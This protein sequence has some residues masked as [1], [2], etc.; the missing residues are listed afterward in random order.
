[1]RCPLD[2]SAVQ[3]AAPL[4]QLIHAVRK[5]FV[6]DPGLTERASALLETTSL[7]DAE[8]RLLRALITLYS[9]P[10]SRYLNFYG[11]PGAVPTVPVY[12]VLGKS[13]ATAALTGRVVFVGLS[14]LN[15]PHEDDFPTVFSRADG[16]DIAGVEIAATAFA[17]LLDDRL[18]QP[19]APW[20]ELAWLGLF[21]CAIGLIARLLPA[22]VAVPAA[23]L[24][25]IL[26]YA[27][28]QIA[29]V[30]D[31]LWLP[32]SIPLLIQL[33]LGMF[34]G[35]L[36]QYRDARR[37]RAN[38][39]RGMQYYLPDKIARGFAE[40]AVD[41]ST[42]KEHVFAVCMV[43]DASRFTTLAEG[44]TP[45][46]LSA[47]L[48]QYF[49]I[50]FGLVERHGGLVTDVVGD[51]TTSVWTAPRP[52]RAAR[53]GACRAA[54][55]ISRAIDA[56]NQRNHPRTMP[57]RIGLN[58]GWAMVGNVGGSGR[59]VY[60]VVGDCVNTASRLESLNKQLGTRI[61]AARALVED[62]D[63]IVSRPLGRFQ[64]CG[65]GEAMQLV[66]LVG[67]AAEA[68]RA[69]PLAEF[70]AALTA[71]EQG[72][73]R[74]AGGHFARVLASDPSDGPARFYQTR[75]QRYLTGAPP[76]VAGVIQLEQK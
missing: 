53:L 56:F 40:A 73:W 61:I 12:Q 69:G 37:A 13:A 10:D 2:A 26:L 42:L 57:T 29:F 49:A 20:A 65:K 41:P 1:M 9:G 35:L 38:I 28:A 39:S 17:N 27:G 33:P 21:G 32:V 6:A 19:A 55:E 3:R 31:Q 11:P 5:A 63:E 15:N 64:L 75:C 46:E 25:A 67:I 16:V 48:D 30:R 68:E 43:T 71:F 7:P 36:L 52:D 22:A 72:R 58:A 8:Q 59:Y 24:I 18:V 34:M 70:A 4:R 14:D 45:K 54:L 60:S 50:L 66:E 47:V 23:L 62:L 44:M 74:E 76:P 51:G